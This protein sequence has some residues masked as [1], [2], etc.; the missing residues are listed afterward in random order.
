MAYIHTQTKC[1]RGS[2]F[3]VR[4][5]DKMREGIEAAFLSVSAISA[6]GCDVSTG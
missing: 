6:A 5:G 4:I 1:A 3:F 2:G